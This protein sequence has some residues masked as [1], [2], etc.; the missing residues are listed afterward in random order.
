[1]PRINPS[2]CACSQELEHFHIH[3]GFTNIRV[4]D[5]GNTTYYH[6]EYRWRMQIQR[7]TALSQISPQRSQGSK[8]WMIDRETFS[9]PLLM[10]SLMFQRNPL[11]VVW[12]LEHQVVGRTSGTQKIIRHNQ[13]VNPTKS[14]WGGGQL[15]Q[16][17]YYNI[18]SSDWVCWPQHQ[19]YRLR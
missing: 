6:D 10:F 19:L 7:K 2:A 18:R 15:P 3:Q 14:L 17:R 8:I 16:S 11:D 13:G 12:N 5:P 1:M 4:R 9:T